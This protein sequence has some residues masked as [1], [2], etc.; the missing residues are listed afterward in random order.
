[1]VSRPIYNAKYNFKFV[2]SHHLEVPRF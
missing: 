1:V 2:I